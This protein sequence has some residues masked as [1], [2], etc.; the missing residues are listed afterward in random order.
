MKL[1]S[2]FK[3]EKLKIKAHKKRGRGEA[4]LVGT[5][6]A[7]Y[8]PDSFTQ[9]YGIV[10]SRRQALN[11]SDR[12][13]M[14]GHS[15]SQRQN[16]TLLLDGTGVD[17]IGILRP[18]LKSVRE[19]VTEFLDLAYRMNGDTHEPNFLLLKWGKDMSFSCRLE[20]VS[21]S[22]TSFDRGGDPLRAVLEV[23][24]ISDEEVA[25]R[26]GGEGKNSPDVTHSRIVK[27]GDTLP[28]LAR[29][30]Y[31]SA[32]YYLLLARANELDNFRDLQPGQVIVF[33]PLD[34]AERPTR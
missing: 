14:Y 5:F 30:V 25:K 10:Y 11:S 22:Y 26:V 17:S 19:R 4:D 24:L 13:Q 27:A 33:P 23:Q 15:E 1:E 20:Q 12:E 3:L 7:M 2:A 21:I 32:D 34:A 16:L 9:D 18:T 8:N 31:G 28:L 29:E 6:E